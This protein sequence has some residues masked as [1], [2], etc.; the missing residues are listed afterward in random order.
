MLPQCFFENDLPLD[1]HSERTWGPGIY[2]THRQRFLLNQIWICQG[3]GT[4]LSASHNPR[5]NE[6]DKSIGGPRSIRLYIG[7]EAD[8]KKC[9]LDIAYPIKN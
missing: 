3:R 7:E 6:V 8:E 1:D 5:S 2:V 9:E 4:L